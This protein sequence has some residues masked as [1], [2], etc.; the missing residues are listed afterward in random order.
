MLQ[1]RI[2][3]IPIVARVEKLKN[4]GVAGGLPV[5]AHFPQ[6]QPHQGMEPVQNAGKIHQDACQGVLMPV[7]L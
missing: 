5:T 3:I 6:S 1:Q 7:M 4:S 2:T